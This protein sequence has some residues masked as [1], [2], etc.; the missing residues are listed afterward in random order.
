MSYF[1]NGALVSSVEYPPTCYV[2]C[3]S[4]STELA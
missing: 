3:R 1:H 4:P 2:R